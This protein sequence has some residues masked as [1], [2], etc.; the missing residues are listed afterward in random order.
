[1]LSII[2]LLL[3]FPIGWLL[4]NSGPG[5][6]L[7][8]SLVVF[9]IITD[10]LDGKIAR[11]SKTVSNWGKV[12][13][14]LAD[15]LGGGIIIISLGLAKLIPTWFVGM[16]IVRDVSIFIMWIHTARVTGDIYMSKM[17]GKI[18]VGLMAITAFAIITNRFREYWDYLIWVT[19]FA[20]IASFVY[21]VYM[22]IRNLRAIKAGKPAI[23][24]PG[25]SKL[26]V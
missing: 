11:W 9:A 18:A 6:M 1:M 20:M 25:G 3:C 21:Y 10:F 17:A 12:L 16:M 14:P 15:K 26:A 5:G 8:I 2:R 22:Y 4:V 24:K 19:A 23:E 13:D 7:L